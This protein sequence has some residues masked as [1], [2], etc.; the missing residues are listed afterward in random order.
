MRQRYRAG[1]DINQ[2]QPHSARIRFIEN[3]DPVDVT[4]WGD[5]TIELVE[6]HIAQLPVEFDDTQFFRSIS[7]SQFSR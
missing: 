3:D 1:G 2:I 5:R 6:K 4:A 7:T